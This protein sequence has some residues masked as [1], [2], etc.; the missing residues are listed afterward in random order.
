MN[1]ERCSSGVGD[2]LSSVRAH[3]DPKISLPWLSFHDISQCYTPFLFIS[4]RHD[5]ELGKHCLF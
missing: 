3:R 1:T 2:R 4:A 5:D